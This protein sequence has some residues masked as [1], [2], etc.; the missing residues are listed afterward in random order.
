MIFSS[1]VQPHKYYVTLLASLT[2][3]ISADKIES[4]SISLG[5]VIPFEATQVVYHDLYLYNYT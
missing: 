5:R 2:L 4:N 1:K 3:T